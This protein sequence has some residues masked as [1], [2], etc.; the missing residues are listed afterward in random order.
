MNN[1]NR[2]EMRQKRLDWIETRGEK[3]IS[4]ITVA[5]I[6]VFLLLLLPLILIVVIILIIIPSDAS[7]AAGSLSV[8][9]HTIDIQCGIC[10]RIESNEFRLSDRSNTWR[11]RRETSAGDDRMLLVSFEGAGLNG[12]AR[13]SA[14]DNDNVHWE[15]VETCLGDESVSERDAHKTSN[16]SELNGSSERQGQRVEW[17]WVFDNVATRHYDRVHAVRDTEPTTDRNHRADQQTG[18]R[19]QQ[20]RAEMLEIVVRQAVNW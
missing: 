14:T 10:L 16:W 6:V 11:N 17:R 3:K 13:R 5:V 7:I 2:S 9:C 8:D 15:T 18:E 19:R 12:R 20:R 4:H 1:S